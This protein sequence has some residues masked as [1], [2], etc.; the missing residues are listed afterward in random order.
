MLALKKWRSN[1]INIGKTKKMKQAYSKG[2]TLSIT[3]LFLIINICNAQEFT[4]QV[5]KNNSKIGYITIN[6]TTLDSK[7]EYNLSSEIK[8]WALLN[9]NINGQEKSIFE[10]GELKYSSVDREMNKKRKVDKE[11]LY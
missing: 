3:V 5:W 1:P 9:L 4:F 2:I 8:T 7:V 6:K 10:N 11:L